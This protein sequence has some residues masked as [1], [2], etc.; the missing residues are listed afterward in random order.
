[1]GDGVERMADDRRR[2]AR[3]PVWRWVPRQKVLRWL[4]HGGLG[5]RRAASIV[6]CRRACGAVADVREARWRLPAQ[7][8]PSRVWG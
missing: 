3:M 1:V 7:R 5:K 8:G 4:V 2:G 6:A